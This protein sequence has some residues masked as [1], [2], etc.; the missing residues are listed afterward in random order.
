MVVVVAD[1]FMIAVGVWGR[2]MTICYASRLCTDVG[3]PCPFFPRLGSIRDNIQLHLQKPSWLYGDSSRFA[4][5]CSTNAHPRV[6]WVLFLTTVDRR[7]VFRPRSPYRGWSDY[8]DRTHHKCA[9]SF[10]TQGV[11]A[12][13]R[14]QRPYHGQ[15]R[16]EA[17][18]LHD[19]SFGKPQGQPTPEE[20]EGRLRSA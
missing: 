10:D 2:V 20:V 7:L 1:V 19:S 17:H 9:P 4:R 11:R 14:G 18:Q 5:T 12:L 8:A 13:G 16:R 15:F 3:P 6:A